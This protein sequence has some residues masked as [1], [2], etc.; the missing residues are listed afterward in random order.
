MDAAGLVMSQEQASDAGD[1]LVECLRRWHTMR[2]ACV[3]AN[4]KRWAFRPKQNML[5]NQSV[6]QD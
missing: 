2:N 1:S 3:Q 4:M 6:G 5:Q